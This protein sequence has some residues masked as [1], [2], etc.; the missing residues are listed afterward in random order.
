[1]DLIKEIQR[2]LKKAKK[3]YNFYNEK[4][5]ST[6]DYSFDDNARRLYHRAQIDAFEN[7]LI[8]YKIR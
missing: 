5:K 6:N 4:I 3:E 1:M 8:Y 7:I 2:L